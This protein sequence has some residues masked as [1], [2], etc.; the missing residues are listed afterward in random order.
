MPIEGEQR[1]AITPPNPEDDLVAVFHDGIIGAVAGFVGTV[2]MTVVL[3]IGQLL[4]VFDLT[5]FAS[6]A[7]L[8]GLDVLFDES[9][10]PYLG[11]LV[12]LAG[13][14]TTW[15]LIFA[16]IERFLPGTSLPKRG[17]SFGTVM[18][19]GFVIAFVDVLPPNPATTQIAL[20]AGFT[21][22][23]HWIYGYGLGWVFDYSL[24]RDF[25]A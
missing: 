23:A 25:F 4:G 24:E 15:P 3:G 11:Y 9:L 7:E 10:M 6:I 14:M 2:S 12:F 18:W 1:G 19:T 16:A 17:V 20:Y 22:L 21:L 5:T 13:G 8:G